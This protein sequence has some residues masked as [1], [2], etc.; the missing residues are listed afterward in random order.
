MDPSVY[1]EGGDGHKGQV[2]R[3]SGGCVNTKLAHKS[4][5]NH[6]EELSW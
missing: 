3:S 5:L 1:M 6:S 4:Y 2:M